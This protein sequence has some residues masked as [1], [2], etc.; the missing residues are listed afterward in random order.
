M[1]VVEDQLGRAAADVDH[2]RAGGGMNAAPRQQR[3]L[4]AAGEARDE[5]IAPLDLTE[6]CLAVLRVA[7][8][9]RRDRERTLGAE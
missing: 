2:E 8:G 4:V 1:E 3:L 7:D 9:A 6:K 5:A